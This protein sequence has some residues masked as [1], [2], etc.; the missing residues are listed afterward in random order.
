[1]YP[2]KNSHFKKKNRH[3]LLQPTFSSFCGRF[4]P[5]MYITSH[6]TYKV[7]DFSQFFFWTI[8]NRT[9]HPQKHYFRL[10]KMHGVH[11]L[12]FVVGV[13]EHVVVPHFRFP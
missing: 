6:H 12:D 9:L 2:K 11:T 13:G 10:Y 1:M 8:Q 3:M 5:E 7:L 4:L